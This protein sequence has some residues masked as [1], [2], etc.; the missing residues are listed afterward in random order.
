MCKSWNGLIMTLW[1]IE[2]EYTTPLLARAHKVTLLPTVFLSYPRA[3][4]SLQ[5]KTCILQ[6]VNNLVLNLEFA[7][8]YIIIH[9]NESTNQMQQFP[10]FIACHL[11]TA[12]HVSGILMPIIRSSTT[13]VA[14]SGL[15]LECGASSAVGRCRA[16]W[17]DHDQ[18][19]CYH[20][21]P[22]VNQRLLLQLLSLWWWAW[23]CPKHVEPYLNDE[24]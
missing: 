12:Q 22:T 21:A 14:A 7:S 2:L 8:P 6:Q 11:N 17:P 13:A 24:Q 1:N 16:G 10:R 15:P 5:L 19:H 18:Q 3:H 23:G 9:S 4:V 20:H